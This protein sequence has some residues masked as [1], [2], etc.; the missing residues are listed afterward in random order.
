MHRQMVFE[1]DHPVEGTIKQRAFPARFSDTE[2]KRDMPPP[3]YGQHTDEI[4]TGLGYTRD[5]IK[6]LREEK[7][8]A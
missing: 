5:D 2:L 1:M 3:L 7:V 8:V 6:K 4:L